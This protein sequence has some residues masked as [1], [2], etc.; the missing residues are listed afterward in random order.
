MTMMGKGRPT[1]PLAVDARVFETIS[2]DRGLD[3][4][5]PLIFELGRAGMSGVDGVL[6]VRGGS[7]P[8]GVRRGG[9]GAV[10]IDV[11]D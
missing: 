5:E 10:E 1:E 11:E 2:G 9:I 6:D 3:H 7:G 8:I 4:E